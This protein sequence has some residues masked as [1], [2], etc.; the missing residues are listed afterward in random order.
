M[1][2]L[3]TEDYTDFDTFDEPLRIKKGDTAILI[4][5]I[6]GRVEFNDKADYPVQIEG[7]P[8]GCYILERTDL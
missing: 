1:I 2:I 5:E 4:D 6:N 3:F 8:R 7:V